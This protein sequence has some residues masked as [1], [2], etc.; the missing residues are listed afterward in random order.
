MSKYAKINS[1]NIVEN[2]IISEDSFVAEMIGFFVKETEQTKKADIGDFWDK[3]NNKF[4]SPKMYNSWILNS[5]FEWE[6]PVGPKPSDG[7]YVWKEDSLEWIKQTP[8][9]TR[10]SEN[11]IW[12]SETS[13]WVLP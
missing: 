1:E 8:G 3:Q 6:S 4:I 11:H 2:I 5:E 10:P 9:Q 12:N 13:S 7:D